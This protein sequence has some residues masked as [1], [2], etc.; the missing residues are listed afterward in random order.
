MRR[1]RGEAGASVH[2]WT[3]PGP[4]PPGG[5]EPGPGE[6]L[7]YLCGHWRLF[8]LAR[9]HRFS[10]D[11]LLCA[12][13]GT[14]WAPRAE[15]VLDLGSGIGSVALAAAWRLPGARFVTV[16]AQE[17]SLRLARKSV[18]YDGAAGRFRLLLGDFREPEVL[19]GEAPFD[20]VLGSPPYFPRGTV[21]EPAH[22]Q[23]V[24][25]RVEL[26]G[27]VADY[28]RAAGRHLAPGGLFAFVLDAGDGGRARDAL[29][30]AGLL[31][32]RS[33]DVVFKEGE[34]PRITLF[35]AAREAD[36]PGA[37]ARAPGVPHE[38]PR[39][40]VRRRDGT[41]HPEYALVRLSM[42]FPPG[43]LPSAL[44]TPDRSGR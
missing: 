39:L 13:Y 37:L 14:Q 12:W 18:S 11:D 8:Q 38:E 4:V 31:L 44:G 32:L 5:L 15:R 28:A 40:V 30:G 43:D 29:A 35:S 41:T 33:R 16:E 22:P 24:P 34:R 7:D 17:V 26:R 2:G 3:R 19:S 36:L 1:T 6:T 10:T 27:T 25:A 23:A 42:G 21:T 20:L 9:G